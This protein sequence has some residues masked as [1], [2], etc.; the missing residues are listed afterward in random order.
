MW[1]AHEQD[2]GEESVANGSQDIITHFAFLPG[3]QSPFGFVLQYDI[4]PLTLVSFW[5]VVC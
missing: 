2:E 3:S 5:K 4:F 1:V